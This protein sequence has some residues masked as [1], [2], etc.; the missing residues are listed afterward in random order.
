MKHGEKRTGS[1]EG[2]IRT[3]FGEDG[4]WDVV[5]WFGEKEGF[6]FL[7]ESYLVLFDDMFV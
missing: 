2:E 5:F 7:N 1:V 6:E 4:E 3:A